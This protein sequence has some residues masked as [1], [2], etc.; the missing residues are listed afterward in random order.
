[1]SLGKADIQ[2]T[3][4]SGVVEKTASQWYEDD[5]KY[6]ILDPDGWDRSVSN[7]VCRGAV[8]WYET[9]ITFEKYKNKR[10]KCTVTD[11][12]RNGHR[13]P[14]DIRMSKKP[15]ASCIMI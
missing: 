4:R 5:I 3:P 14:F 15:N 6:D 8:K 10:D 1:M 7:G 2:R 12:M 9:R 13:Q 11:Y